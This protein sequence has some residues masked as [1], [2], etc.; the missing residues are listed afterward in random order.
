MFTDWYYQTA[1]QVNS[2]TNQNLQNGNGPPTANNILING[3]NKNAKGGGSY[4]KVT[5]QSGKKYA[6]FQRC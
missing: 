4:N 1:W 6:A 2:I 3:T 5:I